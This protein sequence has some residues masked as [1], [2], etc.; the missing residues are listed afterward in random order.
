[1][2]ALLGSPQARPPAANVL[3]EG[4]AKAQLRAAYL[5][6]GDLLAVVDDERSRDTALGPTLAATLEHPV[7]GDVCRFALTAEATALRRRVGSVWS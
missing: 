3:V 4:L 1:M 2:A 5:V 7:A 6:T